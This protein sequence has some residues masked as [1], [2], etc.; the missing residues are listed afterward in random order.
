M[1]GDDGILKWE[2]SD[3]WV[4][5][6]GWRYDVRNVWDVGNVWSRRGNV[7]NVW[8]VRSRGGDVRGFDDGE[9]YGVR[10]GGGWVGDGE[11]GKEE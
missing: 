4:Y 7:R 1:I 2:S 11:C 5:V 3:V 10:I 6:R 9:Y 8:N